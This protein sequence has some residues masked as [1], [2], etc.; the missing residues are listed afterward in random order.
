MKQSDMIWMCL[1]QGLDEL[2][3][4]VR[5]ERTE[6]AY[7]IWFDEKKERSEKTDATRI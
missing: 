4:I 7:D 2:F 5:F 3:E 6:Q 1:P